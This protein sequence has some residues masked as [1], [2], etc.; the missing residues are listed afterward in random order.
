MNELAI[1]LQNVNKHFNYFDLNNVNL[2]LPKGQI[3]GFVGANGAGKST[4]IRIIM[5]LMQADNGT[6]TVL[7][8]EM[9]KFQTQIKHHV[10]YS[11]EEMKLYGGKNLGW[12]MAF[13]KS[14][15]PG[16][17]D[18]YAKEL[19]QR[20]DLNLEQKIKQFSKGQHIKAQLL[21][22]LARKPKL[23]VLD[24]PTTGL[25]PVARQEVNN[26]L[27]LILKDEERTVLFSSH[28]TAD[29]EKI[30]DQITFIDRGAIIDTNDKET[31]LENWRRIQVELPSDK[32]MVPMGNIVQIEQDGRLAS[33]I[34]NHFCHSILEAYQQQ[35]IKVLAV[36][37]MTLEEI[38]LA[39]VNHRRQAQNIGAK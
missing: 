16:W 1:Q 14:I 29:V 20:F 2:T 11:S 33:V 23:L 8:Q 3:M 30:S 31:F 5:G 22:V 38:F 7:G 34:S 26:E 25:D 4:T 24:E 21:L 13:I 6:A 12:H 32:P 17:D 10:G 28:N 18:N 36:E 19:L 9:P 37:N 15:Y 27:A 35:N 39:N